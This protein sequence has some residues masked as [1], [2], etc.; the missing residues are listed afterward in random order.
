MLIARQNNQKP[1]ETE[2]VHLN[3]ELQVKKLKKIPKDKLLDK[4]LI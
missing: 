4:I 3:I 1:T 2:L